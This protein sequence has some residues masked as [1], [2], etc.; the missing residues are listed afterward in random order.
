MSERITF[1]KHIDE[2]NK[3]DHHRIVMDSYSPSMSEVLEDFKY[4]LLACGYSPKNVDQI[5]IVHEE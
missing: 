2:D 4:F 1:I 5:E 3:Y